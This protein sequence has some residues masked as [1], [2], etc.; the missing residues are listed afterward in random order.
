MQH[1]LAQ[2]AQTTG[3][4]L[5]SCGLIMQLTEFLFLVATLALTLIIILPFT[6]VLVRF[7]ANYN[8]KALRLDV[9]GGAQAH[10]GPVIRS[11]FEMM[12][13]VY[14]LEVGIQV[15]PQLLRPLTACHLPIELAWTLQGLK[16][17]FSRSYLYRITIDYVHQCQ[18]Y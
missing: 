4:N 1:P 11:Y 7:R 15:L 18:H 8:P 2:S 12:V 5:L 17:G 14:R 3:F 13:R 9:E 10:T 6:G 16:C